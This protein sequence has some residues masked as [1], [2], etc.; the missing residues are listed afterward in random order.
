VYAGPRHARNR[1]AVD[2][3]PAHP[4]G[5]LCHRARAASLSEDR[6]SPSG[7]PRPR[8]G[9]HSRES[10]LRPCHRR[11][12]A[13]QGH[14]ALAALGFVGGRAP[15]QST[16]QRL[17][18]KLDSP[19]ISHALSAYF[20]PTVAPGQAE[21]GGQGIAIDGKAQRGRLRY[22]DGGS[23]VHALRVFC[24]DHGVVL[25][26]EPIQHGKEK[27][28]AELTVAPAL[29][30][31]LDWAGRVLTGDA[32]FCQRHLCQQVLAASGDYLPLVRE[33]QPALHYDLR[34]LFDPPA[35]DPGL[36][37][38]DR[39]EVATVEKGH[40]RTHDRRHPIASADM[41]GCSDWPGLA[42]VFRLEHT[43]REDGQPK[44]ALHYGVTSLP[45]HVAS[46]Q[47]L[48][49]LKRG[50][51]G[52]ENGLHRVK[53]VTLGEDATRCIKLRGQVSWR[54]YG[55]RRSV[56]CAT[57]ATA[58]S[59]VGSATMRVDQQKR[60][61]SSSAHLLAHKPCVVPGERSA[62]QASHHRRMTKEESQR[63]CGGGR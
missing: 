11:E 44:R 1:Y 37:P 16:L 48:P 9:R 27:R 41:V 39:R 62:A 35:G 22:Q 56:S 54:S 3:R 51:W 59:P 63:S 49:E 32:L 46:A 31:R 19:A 33:N 34:L 38:L 21:R 23:P 12:G 55:I 42:Q 20:A 25:A 30:A 6:L 24:H 4:A 8:R 28:E 2:R 36:P 29:V 57:P 40:G 13:P 14:R 43:W 45:P 5:R 58:L 53:D 26:Q 61:P 18:A 60:Q 52:I 17:F 50:H 7:D 10:L 47:R 15:C